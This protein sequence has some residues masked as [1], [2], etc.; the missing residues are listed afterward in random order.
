M[1]NHVDDW[2]RDGYL[3]IPVVLSADEVE[4]L[5]AAVARISDRAT[6]IGS[7]TDHYR[8]HIS[9]ADDGDIGEIA[10]QQVAEPH[11]LGS[12]WMDLARD[13]RVLN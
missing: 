8:L 9:E 4:A 12:E 3:A 1:S 5:R 6:A 7:N 11:E 10:L 13:P 2:S